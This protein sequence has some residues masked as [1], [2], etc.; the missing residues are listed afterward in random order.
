MSWIVESV[1]LMVEMAIHFNSAC[2]LKQL[3]SGIHVAPLGHVK[4]LSSGI[5]VAPLGHVIL[6]TV[7]VLLLNTLYL[8]EKQQI[9]ILLYFGLTPPRDSNARSTSLEACTLTISCNPPVQLDSS[10]ESKHK[11]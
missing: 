3:S 9:P 1:L 5:H 10:L 11:K 4:Q 8:A 7:F 6:I 2:S